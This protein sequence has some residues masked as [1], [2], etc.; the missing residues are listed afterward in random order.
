MIQWEWVYDNFMKS[1]SFK[2]STFLFRGKNQDIIP[3]LSNKESVHATLYY[4]LDILFQEIDLWTVSFEYDSLYICTWPFEFW[5][6]N[7]PIIYWF[8]HLIMLYSLLLLSK[9]INDIQISR[10]NYQQTKEFQPINELHYQNIY[11]RSLNIIFFIK[12]KTLGTDEW[13]DGF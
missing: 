1:K 13:V 8:L 10:I 2:E 7:L 11:H 3:V 4:S 5:R 12:K 9:H 6:R